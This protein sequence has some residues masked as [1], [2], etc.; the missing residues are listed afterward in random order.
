MK[1]RKSSDILLDPLNYWQMKLNINFETEFIRY[2]KLY[3][4][5][6]KKEIRKLDG[7]YYITYSD[8]KCRIITIY[9]MLEPSELYEFKHYLTGCANTSNFVDR[10]T[11]ATFFP[12]LLSFLLPLM[13]NFLNTIYGSNYKYLVLISQ[14]FLGIYYMRF[15][16][17]D[18]KDCMLRSNFY[19][20]MIHILETYNNS[21][22]IGYSYENNN[23]KTV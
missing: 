11:I 18:S 4:K 2:K 22:E 5:L 8:W 13:N 15:L 10:I 3:K 19:N 12:F 9:N 21:S 7:A 20:D 6:A 17:V 14:L 1:I 23:Q 16:I